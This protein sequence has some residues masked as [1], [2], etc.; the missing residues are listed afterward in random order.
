[1]NIQLF[2]HKDEDTVSHPRR[3]WLVWS[4]IFRTGYH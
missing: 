1:M 2:D 4:V 3:L